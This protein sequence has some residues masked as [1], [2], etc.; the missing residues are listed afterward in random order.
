MF[1]IK[2]TRFFIGSKWWISLTVLISLAFAYLLPVMLLTGIRAGFGQLQAEEQR[3]IERVLRFTKTSAEYEESFGNL[4]LEE[5]AQETRIEA[6]SCMFSI[7][8]D[9]VLG[10]TVRR[11]NV[12]AV[13][14]N[15]GEFYCFLTETEDGWRFDVS[16]NAKVCLLDKELYQQCSAAGKDEIFINGMAYHVVGTTEL[17]GIYVPYRALKKGSRGNSYLFLRLKE[18]GE[19]LTVSLPSLSGYRMERELERLEM[20]KSATYT[21]LKSVGTI[22]AV[23]FLLVVLNLTAIWR[24]QYMQLQAMLGVQ[25]AVGMSRSGL[26]LEQAIQNFLLSLGAILLLYLCS[27]FINWIFEGF[28][29]I[30]FSLFGFA[31]ML[32]AAA[33]LA[34]LQSA[35]VTV[36]IYRQSIRMILE[37]TP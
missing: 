27:P 24:E 12:Y 14:K 15:Y 9:V 17:E 3:N 11:S 25:R 22:L 23:L 30:R 16:G 37:G 36:L 1:Y 8:T 28:G 35:I 33:I 29:E 5:A 31:S 7:N 6:A 34:L 18:D 26:F 4:L 21:N 19:S 13:D 10:D 2:L 20:I 32:L